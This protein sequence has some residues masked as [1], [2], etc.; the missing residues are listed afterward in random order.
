MTAQIILPV[1]GRGRQTEENMIQYNNELLTFCNAILEIRARSDFA[2]SSRGWGYAMEGMGI[3]KSQFDAVALLINDCRKD[4]GLPID[5]C[6]EDVSRAFYGI[7]Q[8][9]YETPEQFAQSWIK[10]LMENVWQQYNGVSFWDDKEFYIEMLVEKI[11]LRKMFEPICKKYRI[12]IA[13]AKGWPDINSRAAMMARYKQH[14]A[15]GR[16]PILL[17]CGDFDPSGLKISDTYMDMFQ[18]LAPATGWNPD[19]LIIDRFGLNYDFI[20]QAGLSWIDNLITSSKKNLADPRH[21]DHDQPY[22][23]DYIKRY[24]VRKVEAN[25]IVVQPEMGKKLCLDAILKYLPVDA[26]EIYEEQMQPDR[27]EVLNQIAIQL[28]KVVLE[29]D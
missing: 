23:Q 28:K 4:G 2:F 19:N 7:E 5:I 6:S 21:R 25:A 9:D 20:Q 10:H 1:R 12:P 15:A 11:D 13:N 17:Y 18:E 26:P 8:I 24:G 22:V 27:E 14:E 3:E 29:M 16:Q